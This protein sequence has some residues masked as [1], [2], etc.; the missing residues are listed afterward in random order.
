MGEVHHHA[1][2]VRAYL[3]RGNDKVMCNQPLLKKVLVTIGE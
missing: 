2:R 1:G 3:K